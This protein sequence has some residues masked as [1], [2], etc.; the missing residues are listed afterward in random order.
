MRF[1]TIAKGTLA[2]KP[3]TLPM[4]DTEYPLAVRPLN[5]M[6]SGDALERA[7]AYAKGKGVANPAVGDRLYDLG[8]MVHTIAIGCVCADDATLPFFDGGA[9]QILAHLDADRIAYLYEQHQAWQDECGV[10]ANGITGGDFIL[11]V[12]EVANARADEDPLAPLRPSTRRAFERTL[13][14]LYVTSLQGK[15]SSTPD[16]S[17]STKSDA[18]SPDVAPAVAP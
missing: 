3:V 10:R 8:L 14:N 7:A 13:A 9:E 5:G 16:S 4:G 6:E 2:T 15:S 11:K 18:P 12:M 1:S 17:S